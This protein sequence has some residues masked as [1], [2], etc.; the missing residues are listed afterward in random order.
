MISGKRLFT[1]GKLL[2]K[3]DKDRIAMGSSSELPYWSNK[4]NSQG[5][6]LKK[7]QPFSGASSICQ[8]AGFHHVC[9]LLIFKTPW[10]WGV[11]DENR[12]G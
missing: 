7:F 6:C 12:A 5:M 4:D 9:G 2:A 1:L 11:G 8:A 3:L 10:T